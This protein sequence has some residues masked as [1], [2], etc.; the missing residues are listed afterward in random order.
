MRPPLHTNLLAN[1]TF[2]TG[3]GT[4]WTLNTGW[5]VAL[6]GTPWG[7]QYMGI[8]APAGGTSA[9]R[10][11]T[12]IIVTPGGIVAASCWAIGEPSSG[13]FTTLR[14]TFYD[15][16]DAQIGDSRWVYGPTNN[17]VWKQVL[18]RATAPTNSVYAIVDFAVFNNTSSFGRWACTNFIGTYLPGA[19]GYEPVTYKQSLQYYLN[20]FTSQYKMSPR[21]NLWQAALMQPIDDLTNCLQTINIDYDLDNAFG[22]QLDVLGEIIG[23]RRTVPFQP[24]GGISPVLDDETYR[25]LL[26]ATQAIDTWNGKT[27]SLYPIWQFI[28]PGV[29]LIINDNQNMTAQINYGGPSLTSIEKDLIVN[30]MIVPRPETVQYIYS[31][32]T[33]V[34]FGFDLNT[35]TVAGFDTGHFA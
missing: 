27:A 13:G 2:A 1:P 24:S 26:Y 10:N 15:E 20:L 34:L 31:A 29:S 21:L 18:I 6:G 17:Y 11:N 16:N 8:F 4:G 3:D 32:N 19:V 22:V 9:I 33:L 35:S 28:F 25:T 30:G 5:S 14:I 12:Q 23:V 7:N